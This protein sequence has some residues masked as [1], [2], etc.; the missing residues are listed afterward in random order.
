M[1]LSHPGN[2]RLRR[3]G[4]VSDAERR[5]LIL[6]FTQGKR[7]FLLVGLG[8][9]LDRQVHDRLRKFDGFQNDRIFLVAKG[10]SRIRLLETHKSNDIPAMGRLDHFLFIG[11]H[12]HDL[13]DPLIF[14]LD[15]IK[16]RLAGID[17]P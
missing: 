7:Q 1:Q 13:G 3:L 11:M 12:T 4:I 6:Q 16:D 10:I 5:I 9:C 17:L 14:T 8:L 15:G 2:D